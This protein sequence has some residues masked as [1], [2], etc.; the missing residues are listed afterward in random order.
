M[1]RIN[2]QIRISPVRLIDDNNVQ[3]GVVPTSE[4]QQRAR[5]AGLDLVEVSP[6][7][8]PPVCRIMDY[9]RYKYQL[10]KKQKDRGPREQMLKEVRLRP[11][12]DDH[13]REI[14][15]NRAKKFLEEGSKVQFTMLFRGRERAHLDIGMVMFRTI[16]EQFGEEVKVERPPKMENRRMT[17]VVGPVKH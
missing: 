14:K 5:E 12:T 16:L 15:I 1:L 13:D 10:K 3:V 11:K 8:R 6:M 9:G 4:A 7:E 17:M 2:E